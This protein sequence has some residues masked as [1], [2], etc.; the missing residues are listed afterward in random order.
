MF[1]RLLC[2]SLALFLICALQIS[3]PSAAGSSERYIKAGIAYGGAAVSSC[4]V[5]SDAGFILAR[6]GNGG[7]EEILDL[8]GN[9]ELTITIISSTIAAKDNSGQIVYEGFD[10]DTCLISS[11]GNIVRYNNKPYRGGFCFY[12]TTGGKMNVINYIELESYLYGV[13]PSEMGY[14]N[15]IEALKAQAVT[16]RSYAVR[17]T[18]KHK[19]DGFDVCSDIH[20]Q[21]YSGYADE[22]KETNRAVDETAGLVL[23]YGGEPVSGYY[24][25]NSGGHTQNVSDVWSGSAPY[26]AGIKDEYSP[27]YI[28][29]YEMKFQ[30]AGQLLSAAGLG[31]GR[32]EGLTVK[33]RNASGAVAILE[34]K[35]TSGTTEL[36][37]ENIRTVLG[38]ANIKSRMF[39]FSRSFNAGTNTDEAMYVIGA[40]GKA[41]RMKL[42]EIY[43]YPG[44]LL[45]EV[46]GRLQTEDMVEAAVNDPVTFYG[47][48][49]GHGV[50]MPQD[51]AIEM[52]KRGFTF[53]EILR[54]FYSGIEIK[55][56]QGQ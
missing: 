24:F 40:G 2:A 13:L 51:S 50:G 4:Q 20:C 21:I 41:E 19:S 53:E 8:S 31:V 26:L 27:E 44:R 23:T 38:G 48:G 46:S 1:F 22:Y 14:K 49:Y 9:N 7:F 33:K 30:E 32:V 43:V 39:S 42:S 45:L 47:T 5:K 10:R 28:W 15:P 12:K 29:S 3:F 6:A 16:A 56:G 37:G 18:D 17:Y 54:Y 55:Q 35:G 11:D 34:I 52:A 36:K 25:K